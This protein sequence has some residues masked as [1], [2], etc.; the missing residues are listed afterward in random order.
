[1]SYQFQKGTYLFHKDPNMNYQL[2]RWMTF[3]NIPEPEIR[4]IAGRIHDLSD[5]RREFLLLAGKAKQ[6]G[7]ILKEACS[8]RAVDF[9]MN[10]SDKE[11]QSN[12]ER[13][14]K[15]FREAYKSV[16]Q[17]GQ[18][19]EQYSRGYQTGYPADV[20]NGGSFY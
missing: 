14:V 12:Y 18:I 9:F 3:G 19:T 20:R 1:M 2:N 6:E 10:Y 4:E 16:F 15:L 5:W 17:S 7:D 13:L 11:K 8:Y